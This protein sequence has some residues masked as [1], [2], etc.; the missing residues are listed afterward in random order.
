M[1]ENKLIQALIDR[2]K[3]ITDGLVENPQPDHSRYMKQVGIAMGIDEALTLL[4]NLLHAD[5]E[6]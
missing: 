4:H 3:E 6:Q 1:I 2:R 5:D